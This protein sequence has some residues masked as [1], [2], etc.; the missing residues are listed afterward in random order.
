MDI[1]RTPKP[2]AG[3]YKSM[4]PREDEIVLEPAFYWARNDESTNFDHALISSNCDTVRITTINA[5]GEHLIVEGG[6]D[7]EQFPHLKY[8]PFSF[9]VGGKVGHDSWGDVRVDGL[10]DGKV[11]ISK[12]QSGS[13]ADYKFLVLPDETNLVA[14]GADSVRVVLRSVDEFGA[15]R[16]FAADAITFTLSGPATF[17]GE[18]PFGLIGGTGAIWLRTTHMPGTITLA[19]K[20]PYLGTVTVSLTST[21]AAPETV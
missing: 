15:L 3:F 8:P 18:N 16:H 20:H 9:L 11:V 7:R 4:A 13:G 2:A 6:P 12:R 17:I 19:A 5:A 1:F 10:I 14:D 21:A